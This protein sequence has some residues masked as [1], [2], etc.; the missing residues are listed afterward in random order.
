MGKISKA[1]FG[2]FLES[3]D[4]GEVIART[5]VTD[6]CPLAAYF[7]SKPNM[8][9]VHVNAVKGRQAYVD[10]L[11]VGRNRFYAVDLPIW[12]DRF[13]KIVDNADPETE[14]AEE[15]DITAGECLSILERV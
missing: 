13:I 4:E 5:G 6:S 14:L 2:Q 8:V 12:C 7:G 3:F 10:Y 9:A 11:S 15:R 1:S